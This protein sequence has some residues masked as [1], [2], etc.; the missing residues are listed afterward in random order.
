MQDAAASKEK[1]K[2]RKDDAEWIDNTLEVVSWYDMRVP[3]DANDLIGIDKKG[4]A[5]EGG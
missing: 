4:A 3:R 2:Q 5:G 1:E